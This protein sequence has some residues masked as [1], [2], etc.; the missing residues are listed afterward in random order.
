MEV[1]A[2]SEAKF[3]VTAFE[4]GW[5]VSKPFHHAQ[6]YDFV[7]RRSLAQGW[8]TVQVKTA[9][10]STVGRKKLPARAISLRRCNEKGSRPYQEGEFDLLFAVDGNSFW[11]IPYSEVADIRSQITISGEKYKHFRL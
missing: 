10:D 9:Y 2:Q 6:G 8:E 11:L 7:V 5:E 4:H 1:A 3:I